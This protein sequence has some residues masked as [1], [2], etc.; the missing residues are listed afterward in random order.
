[1]IPEDL[2]PHDCPWPIVLGLDP[3]NRIAGWGAVVRAPDR[4]RLVACG[5]LRPPARADAATR[6]AVIAEQLELLLERTRPAVVALEGAFA[7]RNVRSALRLGEARGVVLATAARRGIAIVEVAPAAAKKAVVGNGAASKTQVASMVA[8][9]LGVELDVPE[10]AT[11]ALALALAQVQ[12]MTRD[13]VLRR[14]TP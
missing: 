11:D 13:D 6:L 1:M 14:A 12:R 3:G 8:T 5:V 10:D 4:P 2:V 7:S 9:V